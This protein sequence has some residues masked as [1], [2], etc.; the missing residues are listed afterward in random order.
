MPFKTNTSEGQAELVC[1]LITTI[2]A[3]T[4]IKMGCWAHKCLFPTKFRRLSTHFWQMT[5]S[6][7]PN[8][9]HKWLGTHKSEKNAWTLQQGLLYFRHRYIP[10]CSGPT[11]LFTSLWTMSGECNSIVTA[12]MPGINTVPFYPQME[13]SYTD[14]EII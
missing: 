3:P 8:F 10:E 14:L 12:H 13:T 9:P 4:L 11:V 2:A 5:V 6:S 1:S 7:K